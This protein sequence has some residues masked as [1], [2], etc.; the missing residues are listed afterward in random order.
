MLMDEGTNI[1]SPCHTLGTTRGEMLDIN[2]HRAPLIHK[3]PLER[4]KVN[5]P[6]PGFRN[7]SRGN[8][9][10]LSDQG[11]PI[12]IDLDLQMHRISPSA[13]C[14]PTKASID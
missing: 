13:S 7:R 9:P 14:S 8:Y 2:P 6:R 4:C 3:T 12:A 10:F 11:Q 1:Y 5:I